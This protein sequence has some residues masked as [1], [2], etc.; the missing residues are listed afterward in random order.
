M[1]KMNDRELEKFVHLQL[2]EKDFD[3][4]LEEF[5]LSCEDVFIL[6]YKQGMISDDTLDEL[7]EVDVH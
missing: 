2:Q 5:D 6:L 7:A 3:E 4:L 1:K